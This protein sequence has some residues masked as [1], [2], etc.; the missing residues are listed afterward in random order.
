MELRGEPEQVVDGDRLRP[1]LPLER[2]LDVL[3]GL[4]A[5]ELLEQEVL[6][7]LEAEVLQGD[8]VLDD[9]VRHPLVELRLDDQVGTQL[10]LEVFGGLPHRGSDGAMVGAELIG[11]RP[12]LET[13]TVSVLY[14]NSSELLTPSP[15]V[16][17]GRGEGVWTSTTRLAP[18]LPNPL[19]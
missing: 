8:R 15:L 1:I 10:D 17:E 6:L 19:P 13:R 12:S 18:S 14:L 9:V 7:D 4:L 16:G 2:P 3:E 11:R 5:V